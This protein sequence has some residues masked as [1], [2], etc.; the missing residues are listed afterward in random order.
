MVNPWEIG[1]SCVVLSWRAFFGE[2]AQQPQRRNWNALTFEILRSPAI[3]VHRSEGFYCTQRFDFI[4]GYSLA[5][6]ADTPPCIVCLKRCSKHTIYFSLWESG[7]PLIGT[8]AH[9]TFSTTPKHLGA[10]ALA[11]R[12]GTSVPRSRTPTRSGL[13]AVR[14]THVSTCC[15]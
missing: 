11:H 14:V 13:E 3:D 10:A 7:R 8:P 9:G 5:L 4:V 12:R 15:H 1:L 2:P 6:A